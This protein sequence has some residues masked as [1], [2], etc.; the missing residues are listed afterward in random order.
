MI[1]IL[2]YNAGNVGSVRYALQRMGQEALLTDDPQ[3]LKQADKVIIPGVGAAGPAMAYLRGQGLDHVI[4]SLQQPVLGICL[5]MQLLCRYSEEGDTGALGIF[6]HDVLRFPERERVPHMGW[7]NCE[8]SS[9][10]LFAGIDAGTDFYFVHSYYASLGTDTVAQ[11]DYILPFSAALQKDNFY[12]VQ[13]HPEKSSDNGR[14]LLHNF[15][16]L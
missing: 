7:N 12:G 10:A 9:G 15:L 3:Q 8:S 1:V 5:G 2:H 14:R 6:E 4:R 16:S 11:T 13:F